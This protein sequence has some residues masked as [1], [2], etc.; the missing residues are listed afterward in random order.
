MITLRQSS[1]SSTPNHIILPCHPLKDGCLILLLRDRHRTN[2]IKPN[3]LRQNDSHLPLSS[4][5]FHLISDIVLDH[6]RHSHTSSSTLIWLNPN[7]SQTL[8]KNRFW[9]PLECSRSLL[10]QIYFVPVFV[11][12]SPNVL[13]LNSDF[14]SPAFLHQLAIEYLQCW[15]EVK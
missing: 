15:S 5:L 1:S 7:R 13:A 9:R 6:L 8:R 10:I 14:L 2:P 3:R 12:I 11:P 4:L